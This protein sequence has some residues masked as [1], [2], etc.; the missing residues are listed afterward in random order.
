MNILISHCFLGEP[1]RYDGASR[2]DRQIIELHRAGHNL[3]PVCPEILGGLDVPRSPAELQPDGRVVT[4]DG[5]DVTAA[6]R[7]GAERV[8]KIARENDCTLAILKARSPSCGS[9]EIYDGTFTHTL[10]GGWGVAARM[11]AEAGIEV[12]DEEHLQAGLYD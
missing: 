12:M 7:A 10:K 2:L 5:Q 6:Y 4:Q 9:G 8:L 3:I 1:C 11:L